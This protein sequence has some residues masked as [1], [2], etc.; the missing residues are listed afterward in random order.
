MRRIDAA[1]LAL[2]AL[3]AGSLAFR[4]GSVPALTGD[5]AWIGVFVERLRS[6]GFVTPHEMNDYTGPLFP[7]AVLGVSS[8]L[9]PGIA[10]L[11]ALGA[12]CNAAAL[13][14]SWA[15]LR[16]R[17]SAE[18]AFAFAVLAAGCA[19]LL[20]K[21]R[22]AWEV[23]AFQPLLVA[24]VAAAVARPRSAFALSVLCVLGTQNH[25]IF[26]SVP[27][28]LVVL[29][30][31]LAAWDGDAEAVPRLRS[32]AAAAAASLAF[33]FV[34]KPISD[35]SWMAHRAEWAGALV[36]APSAAAFAV[37]LVPDSWL[38]EP[39]R[40]LR[41]PLEWVLGLS[42][43][44]FVV[45]HVPPLVEAFAGPVVFRRVFS[46]ALPLPLSALLHLWGLLL[47]ALVVWHAAG[48]RTRKDLGVHE[49][50]LL[51][52]PAALAAV[53]VLFRHTSSLRYYSIPSSVWLLSLSAL[54]PRLPA[55]DRRKLLPAALAFAAF[56]QLVVWRELASPADRRP[57][58]FKVGWRRESSW[59]F[60][61]KDALFAAFDASGACR[62]GHMERSFVAVPLQFWSTTRTVPCDAAKVFDADQCPECE[63]PPYYR[64]SVA[65]AP[66]K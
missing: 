38:L 41:R 50:T 59:D 56:S 5:E 17:V 65:A 46:M 45:W 34:K 44:L 55:L 40:R 4:L 57:L 30:G 27:L 53:F 66:L 28:S 24:G 37:S 25:F 14:A 6:A 62:I 11:R 22:L 19:Y 7:W 58:H 1:A 8:F 43:L 23:Y 31:V 63:R 64:W 36:L 54:A 9:T 10:A 15:H 12:A 20:L 32:A 35:A 42:V 47:A 52:W 39:W 33:A 48:A 13:L 2:L 3:C 16:R 61:R 29:F 49:R 18:A 26:A 51:L 21:S 60:A